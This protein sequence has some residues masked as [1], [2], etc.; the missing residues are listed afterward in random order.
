MTERTSLDRNAI[1]SV[2]D[3]E[4]CQSRLV[5]ATPPGSMNPKIRHDVKNQLG[6]IL[7]FSELLLAGMAA[8]DPRRPDLTEI[9]G[10]TEI[11]MRLVRSL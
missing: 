9:R 11:A 4:F 7:G 2:L 8:D 3:P 5:G 6:I 1:P 10:A